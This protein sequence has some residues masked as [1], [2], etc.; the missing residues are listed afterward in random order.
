MK[1]VKMADFAVAKNPENLKTMSLGS[2]VG[3]TLYDPS[4]KVGGLI[5]AMLP[6]SE[7]ARSTNNRAKFVDTSIPYLV[8]ELV[9]NGVAKRRL[10]AKLVGGADMFSMGNSGTINVGRNNVKKAKEVL[11][12]LD[13]PLVAEETGGNHG[14]T[15]TM[16]TSDGAV[17]I[18][19]IKE[20]NS[21]I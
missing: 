15:T 11:S 6:S 19:S 4:K 20:G 3:I 16:D 2:C 10:E 5:H 14:R 13:I 8:D 17:F 1:L 7:N 12:N 18:R 9:K 21:K